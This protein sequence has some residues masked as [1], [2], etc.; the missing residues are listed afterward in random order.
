MLAACSSTPPASP[1]YHRVE[2]G[3]TLYSIARRYDRSV[4]ELTRWNQLRNPNAIEVA[5][6]L[7]VAPPAGGEASASRAKKPTSS[8][9]ATAPT[10]PAARAPAAP[11][12]GAIKLAWPAEGK[13]ARRGGQPGISIAG[14]A[15]TSVRAAASGRVQYAGNGLRG[16]G[17]LV[18]VGHGGGYLTIYAHNRRIT[19]S[20]GQQVKQGQQIAEMGNTDSAQVALYFEVRHNGT[21]VDPLRML[22]RR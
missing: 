20:Q 13:S 2:K 5:Q 16:Y 22:P 10:R 4:A 11:P 3:E 12:A 1:G 6:L 19:V 18:I 9:K 21:P 14:S 17:N 8:A 15:G 7:R